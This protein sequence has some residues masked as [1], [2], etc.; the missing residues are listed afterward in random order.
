ML[1][2]LA[3][4]S[5]VLMFLAPCSLPLVP[6][7]LAFLSGNTDMSTWG[8]RTVRWRMVRQ[9]CF[10]SLGFGLVFGGVPICANMLL[11]HVKI[12]EFVETA[13]LDIR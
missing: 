12:P 8:D 2:P 13:L 5:G 1:F 7:Y 6:G 9:A 10:V 3:F 4:L 11:L